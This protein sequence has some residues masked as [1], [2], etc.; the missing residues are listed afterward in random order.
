MGCAH[1]SASL[2]LLYQLIK[3]TMNWTGGKL[4]QH[5]KTK[6]HKTAQKQ[7]AQFAK[8]R[9][10]AISGG[11]VRL[12]NA[13]SVARRHESDH[14]DGVERESLRL[15]P[16]GELAVYDS[17][18]CHGVMSPGTTSRPLPSTDPRRSLVSTSKPC[19]P[20]DNSLLTERQAPC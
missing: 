18:P 12:P 10:T 3:T 17:L 7:K 1:D 15:P 2:I 9:A 13:G 19:L 5:S 11:Q 14:S 20:Y 6:A 4:Q 16:P 8:A